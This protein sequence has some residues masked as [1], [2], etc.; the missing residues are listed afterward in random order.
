MHASLMRRARA[1]QLLTI[2]PPDSNSN[3]IKPER[4]PVQ[5]PVHHIQGSTFADPGH[6][7]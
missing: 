6:N 2:L 4:Q 5:G 1:R 3:P 7:A